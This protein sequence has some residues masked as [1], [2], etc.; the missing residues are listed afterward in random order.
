MRLKIPQRVKDKIKAGRVKAAAPPPQKSTKSTPPKSPKSIAP[1]PKKST[2]V[3]GLPPKKSKYSPNPYRNKK[4][5]QHTGKDGLTQ[6]ERW[7]G[8]DPKGVKAPDPLQGFIHWYNDLEPHILKSNNRWELWRLTEAQARIIEATLKVNQETGFFDHELL[9]S[10]SPRRH[11]KSISF[12]M[13]TIYTLMSRANHLIRLLGSTTE[14]SNKTQFHLVSKIIENSPKIKYR[15]YPLKKYITLSEIRYKNQSTISVGSGFRATTAFGEKV[16]ILWVSDFHSFMDLDSYNALSAATLDSENSQIWIDSNVDAIDG[17]VHQLQQ[18]SKHDPQMFHHQIVY[19]NWPDFE[20]RAPKWINRQKAKRLEKTSLPAAFLRDVLGK[21]SEQKN[22]LFPLE[23]REQCQEPY[24]LP[25]HNLE[26]IT[27]GRAYKI[28]AGLDRSKSFSTAFGSDATV[29]SVVCKVA[30]PRHGQAEYWLLSQTIFKVNTAQIIKKQILHDHEKYKLDNSILENYEITDLSPW[31]SSQGI[32][33]E[34]LSATEKLQTSVFSEMFR[35][36]NEK[37][38]HY[39]QDSKQFDSELSTFTYVQKK[40]GRGFGFGHSSRKF[41]DDTVYSAGYAIHSL[42]SMIL[43]SYN[44]S[45]I[46]CLN[47]SPRR[48]FC[49]LM[50]GEMILPGCSPACRAHHEVENMFREYLQFDLES[51]MSL[52]EFFY[53]KVILTGPRI[54][55]AC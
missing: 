33:H 11:G 51:D 44:L 24:T 42:R 18:E 20:Q 40:G 28:G 16:N 46:Q 22:A 8:I 25:I 10:V 45:A 3:D 15:F 36:F 7:Q 14:A 29:W 6:A 9:L 34:T 49:Y 37:R 31:L 1:Q 54:R 55:M 5:G 35:I 19:E 47:K 32:E 17:P 41:H 38:F 26:Q 27:R 21:R 23:I 39:P 2:R 30:S 12:A 52:V 13:L 43:H 50:G 48:N 4:T 53:N